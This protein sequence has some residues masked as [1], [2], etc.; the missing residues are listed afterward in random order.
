VKDLTLN[1]M[2]QNFFRIALRNISRH[3]VFTLL[4]VSGLAVGL[5]ASLLILL[6]VQDEYSYENFNKDAKNIY[7]VEE[8]QF[9]SGERYHVTVTPH[10]S[11]P[12]WK[13]KIPE[14]KEQTRINRLPRILFRQDDK[15]FFETSIVGA[16]SGLFRMF[17]LP[18]LVGDPLTALN[19]P[20]SIVLT[21]KLAAKYFGNASPVGK[22]LTLDNKYLFTVT[23]VM[24]DIPKNSMFSFEGVIPYSFLKEIG[25]S[26][27]SWGSNSIL[28]F[29]QLE[30]GTD[31][32]AINKKLTAI[33]K[34][35]YPQT[36]T[37]FLLF[38]LLNIHLHGQFGFKQNN[39]PVLA[40]TIFTLIAVFVLLIACI[41]FINLSTAKAS[42]RAKEV[43]IKKVA[44]ADQTTMIIQF[45]LE[46]L[47]LAGLSLI[48]ALILV[49]LSLDIFNTISG[50]RFE[51]SDLYQMKFVLSFL[52]VGLVAGLISGIY[53]AFYLS[54]LKPVTV[55]KGE[56]ISGKGNGRLRQILVIVQFTLSIL[57]AISATFMYLQL[58]FL[59][60]KELG[61]DKDNLICIPM[62]ENMKLKYY[63]LKSDLQNETLILGVTASRMN[64][65]RI[66]SNSDGASWDGKD[67]E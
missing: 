60:N 34:E 21:E 56:S 30:S 50:K 47:L 38:P 41:N 53:P 31:I 55:L 62:A 40:V 51:L 66:G 22:N 12:V 58:K 54:A 11:G 46:S 24:K 65:V 61:F 23:G 8:D 6:W 28:T 9:Y 32:T 44:G 29:V 67:P 20:H 2:I 45:M 10:P 52:I 16:D 59:Q 5:T 17:T 3:K 1:T 63:T 14:I 19:A 36:T 25:A 42:A 7:R 26:S 57:I 15:V 27:N 43:G 37:E 48:L 13:E 18:L 39:G 64:P 33:V 4:N 49:G 35:N